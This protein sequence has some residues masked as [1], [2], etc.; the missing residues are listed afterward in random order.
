MYGIANKCLQFKWG[1]NKFFPY[2]FVAIKFT[3]KL[4]YCI[5]LGIFGLNLPIQ[6]LLILGCT[7]N[8]NALCNFFVF[9]LSLYYDMRGKDSWCKHLGQHCYNTLIW[10]ANFYWQWHKLWDNVI[11]TLK[12]LSI[13]C[14]FDTL[15]LLTSS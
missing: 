12:K 10:I 3:A 15:A 14:K 4:R 13:H 9:F 6:W 2:S 1:S 11:P 8:L 5:L 7:T